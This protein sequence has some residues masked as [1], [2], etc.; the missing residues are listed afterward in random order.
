AHNVGQSIVLLGQGIPFLHAGQDMLRSK[1]MDRNSFDSGD[2][3][4]RLDFTYSDN[5]FAVG[6]PRNGENATSLG[7]IR[8]ILNYAEAD[9]SMDDIVSGVNVTRELMEIRSTS[10]LFRLR[11]AAQIR[12]R[13]TYLNTGLGQV[14]GVIVQSIS[15]GEKCTGSD[16]DTRYSRVVSVINPTTTDQTLALLTDATFALHPV[17]VASSDAV[18]RGANHSAAGFFVPARTTAVFVED[19]PQVDCGNLG[20]DV[21][22]RGSFNDFAATDNVR[23]DLRG[24]DTAELTVPLSSDLFFFKVADDTFDVANCGAAVSGAGVTLNAPFTLTCGANSQNVQLDLR[25]ESPEDYVFT[26][27][28]TDAAAPTITVSPANLDLVAPDIAITSPMPNDAV[29]GN[30]VVRADAT[31]AFE[32]TAVRFFVD[33]TLIG[34]DTTPD[35]DEYAIGWD[36]STVADGPRVLT[37]EAE[38]NSGNVGTAAAVTVTV[39]STLLDDNSPPV[40]ALDAVMGPLSG[41]VSLSATASDPQGGIETPTGVSQ[42]SFFYDDGTSAQLIDT[43]TSEPFSVDWDTTTVANGMYTL[44]AEA[45][46]GA[47]NSATSAT[48]DTDVDNAGTFSADLFVCGI[49][50]DCATAPSPDVQ[51]EFAGN[52]T[53]A[54]TLT[55]IGG[56]SYTLRIVNSDGSTIGDI[57][58]CGSESLFTPIIPGQAFAL[59]CSATAN[60]ATFDLS[61]E[62]TGDYVFALDATDTANLILTVTAAGDAPVGVIGDVTAPTVTVDGLLPGGSPA[63]GQQ[64]ITASASDSE[65]PIARVDFAVDG[66]LIWSDTTAPYEAPWA[67]DISANGDRMVTATAVDAAGNEST[68]AALMV[69]LFNLGPID[70]TELNDGTPLP[71]EEQGVYVRGSWDPNFALLDEQQPMDYLGGGI[72]QDTLIGELQDANPGVMFAGNLRFKTGPEGNFD[73]LS[74][75][76]CNPLVDNTPAI[77]NEPLTFICGPEA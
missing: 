77:L 4:N 62:M 3:F 27:D 47:G 37:A 10:R 19:E 32:I 34:T 15:D 55:L 43:A 42:V 23:F 26:L 74:A 59:D 63:G 25:A 45:T 5:N 65:S 1:S 18:V 49:D 53:F 67:T 51:L 48:V 64:T 66:T 20:V 28:V 29:A 40:V 11:N 44:T 76:N 56:T 13:V 14:P 73:D 39:D 46:D 31:D 7:E 50:A 71:P 16:L 24:N 35:G 69:T 70:T 68:S 30:I 60:D 17:Q 41:T 38:D 12:E 8:E 54:G 61:T 6:E 36:T 72:Y 33:G 2:W 21:Y 75:A 22:L 58:D 57:V 52:D 9:P